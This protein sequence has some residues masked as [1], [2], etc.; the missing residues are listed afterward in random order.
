M[1]DYEAR[2][3]DKHFYM[4]YMEFKHMIWDMFLAGKISVSFAPVWNS[5]QT[6]QTQRLWIGM[7]D[8]GGDIRTTLIAIHGFLHDNIRKWYLCYAIQ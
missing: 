4:A 3:R 2:V 7:G 1:Y 5:Y 8:I 6:C